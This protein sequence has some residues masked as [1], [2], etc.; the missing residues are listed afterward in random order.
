MNQIT[1]YLGLQLYKKEWFH[2]FIS[3]VCTPLYYAGLGSIR[4]IYSLDCHWGL[5]PNSRALLSL[6]L[7]IIVHYAINCM[8]DVIHNQQ[9]KPA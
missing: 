9:K 2:V 1:S 4:L 7:A 8:T 3:L 5:Y 6:Y